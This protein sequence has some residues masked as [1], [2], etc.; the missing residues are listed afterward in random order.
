MGR[1][2]TTSIG[3]CDASS[4][5]LTLVDESKVVVTRESPVGQREGEFEPK[6]E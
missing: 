5:G 3:L 6:T 2:G 4:R 1:P